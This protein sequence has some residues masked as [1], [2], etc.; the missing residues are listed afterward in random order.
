MFFG[1]VFMWKWRNA[2]NKLFDQSKPRYE[3]KG[4]NEKLNIYYRIIMWDLIEKLGKEMELDYLQIFKLYCDERSMKII[5]SQEEPSYER[6]YTIP[7]TDEE[8]LGKIYVI[9]DGDHCTMLWADEY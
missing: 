5:H 3:T 2:M 8:I 6:E 4:I 1:S 9:D 7:I